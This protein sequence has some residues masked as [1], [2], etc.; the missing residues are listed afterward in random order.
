MYVDAFFDRDK[1]TVLVS[2]VHNGRTILQEFKPELFFYLEDPKGRYESVFGDKLSRIDHRKYTS[3]MADLKKYRS[4]GKH[5]YEGSVRPLFKTLEKH[6]KTQKKEKLNK[7][8]F[9]IEVQWDKEKGFAPPDDPF[10]KV[11]AISL[12]NSWEDTLYSLSLNPAG[13][14]MEQGEI[15]L[16][17][18]E[19]HVICDSEE[20]MFTIFFALTKDTNVY[21]GWSSEAFDVPYMVNRVSRIMGKEASKNFCL[22]NKFPVKR[23]FE[24]YGKEQETYDFIGKV[25]LDM[26]ALYRKYTYTEQP[27]YRLDFIGELE[28]GENKVPYQGSLEDLYNN[29]Y[30]KFV[31][32]SRQD[33][34]LL[35]KLDK[36][37]DHI[38]LAFTIAHDNL[39]DVKTVM[40]AVALSDNAVVLEAH[41]RNLIT[42]DKVKNSNTESR[43]AGAWVADPNTGLQQRISTVDLTSLYPSIFRTM[44][45]G[46]ETIVAQILHTKTAPF[47][48]EKMG[49]NPDKFAEAW[50][51]I[52]WVQE[53]EDVFNKSDEILK[54]QI[55]G[56][57]TIELTAKEIYDFVF[58]N[59][60]II[61]ANG[62]I[63]RTDK[64]SVISSLLERWFNER[65]MFQKRSKTYA[66]LVDGI[67]LP[68]SLVEKLN[69]KLANK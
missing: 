5:T 51:G 11:T 53:V 4:Q 18:I 6:F 63:I 67:S 64:Q 32:Y 41:R 59:D 55:E 47:I 65:V 8:F 26:L 58:D 56:G 16:E 29:D 48:E 13:M 50:A 10:N 15:E 62:T 31:E 1:N 39:V 57:E 34:L 35:Y 45:L 68:E 36:K 22:W 28:I 21:S 40:G 43:I 2:E 12:Y 38:N 25:H 60:F 17:G 37:L 61:T 69:H 23:M 14:S 7:T 30:R 66:K 44:N 54:L 33:T 42:R 19:N 27:S 24:R 52:F 46:N 9:D 20:Q 49:G 3:F